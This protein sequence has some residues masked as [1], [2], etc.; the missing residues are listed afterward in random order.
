MTDI[1]SK[2]TINV[3]RISVDYIFRICIKYILKH[4]NILRNDSKFIERTL[5][6]IVKKSNILDKEENTIENSSKFQNENSI[7]R[8]KIFKQKSKFIDNREDSNTEDKQFTQCHGGAH[9][10]SGSPHNKNKVPLSLFRKVKGDTSSQLFIN[11]KHC[12]DRIAKVIRE[13]RK[14]EKENKNKDILE[15]DEEEKFQACPHWRHKN[16][17]SPH[18][19]S[20][21]PINLFR[22]MPNDKYSDLFKSC[23]HCRAGN[24]KSTSYHKKK[25][26]E[27][28]IKKDVDKGNICS[29]CEKANSLTGKKSL[30]TICKN[31]TKENVKKEKEK[32]C[33][34]IEELDESAEFRK[35]D[36]EIHEGA[37]KSLYSKKKYQFF[38][39]GKHLIITIVNYLII[40]LIVDNII[41]IPIKRKMP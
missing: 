27:K 10:K 22:K 4:I 28:E 30:E 1:L 19:K 29:Q 26:L 32:R 41:E 13:N 12:R 37:S 18:P 38:F 5:L 2:F 6:K 8:T 25:K 33:K 16:S 11:C 40:V 36:S 7:I 35:C 31:C 34:D 14:E 23:E 24:A 15:E 17:G 9:G 3:L 20:K 21:V 39:L